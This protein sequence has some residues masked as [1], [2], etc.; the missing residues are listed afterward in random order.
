MNV[1]R[2]YEMLLPLR[3][4]DGQPVPEKLLAE[5]ILEVRTKF[6]A[7]SCETQV[8][9]G[10]SEHQ[11]EV[12]RDPL[13]RLFVDV[14]DTRENR[15]FFVQFK[16]RLKQRFKQVDIWMTTYLVEVV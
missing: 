13:A 10:L 3:F 6:G 11:G 9:Q 8:I 12:V 1:L 15:V 14:A 2:R 4:N 5:S 16:E 7:G